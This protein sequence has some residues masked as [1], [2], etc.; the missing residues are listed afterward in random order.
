MS[1]EGVE[2]GERKLLELLREDLA[3]DN[4]LYGCQTEFTEGFSV[5]STPLLNLPTFFEKENIL[6][7]DILKDENFLVITFTSFFV[8][9]FL[10]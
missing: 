2:I 4:V 10:S 3:S 8:T 7:Y 9:Q 6:E 1:S 5:I